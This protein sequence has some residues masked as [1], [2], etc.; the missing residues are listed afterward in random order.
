MFMLLF[1]IFR[2]CKNLRDSN[3]KLSKLVRVQHEEVVSSR[4]QVDRLQKL[5][6]ISWDELKMFEHIGSGSFGEVYH[7]K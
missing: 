1:F 5:W 2:W 4:Q 3:K 6:E 7:G